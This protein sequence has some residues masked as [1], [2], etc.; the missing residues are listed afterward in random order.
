MKHIKSYSEL[1]EIKDKS[2]REW[3]R[4]QNP[5]LKEME[6]EGWDP[7]YIGWLIVLDSSDDITKL[8]TGIEPVDNLLAIDTWEWVEFNEESDTWCASV[9]FS[10]SFGYVFVIPNELI[11][12]AELEPRF[13]KLLTECRELSQKIISNHEKLDAKDKLSP[14]NN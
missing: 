10:N 6:E 4:E 12:D 9:I 2:L 3:L 1:Y 11:A 7:D 14:A 8:G 13:Q 5:W